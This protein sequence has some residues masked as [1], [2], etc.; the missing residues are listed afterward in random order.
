MK[1]RWILAALLICTFNSAN[2][3]CRNYD[4]ISRQANVISRDL[5][6][7]RFEVRTTFPRSWSLYD[8]IQRAEMNASFLYRVTRSGSMPCW[9][10]KSNYTNLQRS[11]DIL[12]NYFRGFSRRRD[13]ARVAYEWRRFI[14]SYRVLERMMLNAREEQMKFKAWVDEYF[15]NSSVDLEILMKA[16]NALVDKED[17][18]ESLIDLDEHHNE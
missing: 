18:I 13:V 16:Y 4:L 9:Q 6:D 15:F 12:R 8:Y 3:A 2:A 14:D 11:V 10:T 5:A 7:L 1:S 17:Q